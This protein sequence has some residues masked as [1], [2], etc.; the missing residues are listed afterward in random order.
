[1]Q[2]VDIRYAPPGDGGPGRELPFRLL[3]LADLGGRARASA[4]PEWRTHQ[5][6]RDN[7][8][9][10]LAAL[11]VQIRCQV[12][13]RLAGH[14]G[15]SGH[16][17]ASGLAGESDLPVSLKI[18]SLADFDPESIAQQI[19]ETRQL[20]DLRASLLA[21]KNLLKSDADFRIRFQRLMEDPES[22][23]RFLSETGRRFP[24]EAGRT[25]PAG[26]AGRAG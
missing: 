24:G 11:R 4:T 21:L 1:M 10:V 23:R 25:A 3:V 26:E 18:G 14:A 22:R 12:A 8:D 15:P 16:A 20:L 9:T 19:P 5:V 7:C 17:G 2:R 6:D 13:N